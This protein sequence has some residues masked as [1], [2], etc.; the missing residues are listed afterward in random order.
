MYKRQLEDSL[1]STTLDSQNVEADRV[2]LGELSTTALQRFWGRWPESTRTACDN[3]WKTVWN[4]PLW[5]ARM[6]RQTGRLSESSLQQRCR[7]Y[8]AVGKKAQKLHV[9]IPA[10]MHSKQQPEV[11]HRLRQADLSDPVST[12]KKE[13]CIRRT[14]AASLPSSSQTFVRPKRDKGCT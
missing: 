5:T 2:T 13:W 8:G 11:K 3:N 12:S 6:W 4:P 1:E 10:T 9:T 14:R 7:G